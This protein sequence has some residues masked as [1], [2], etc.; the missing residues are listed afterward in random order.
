MKNVVELTKIFLKSSF[1]NFNIQIGIQT[2]SKKVFSKLLYF[3]GFLYLVGVLGFLSYSLIDGFINIGQQEVFI[4]VILF[5]IIGF[6]EFQT[7]FTSVNLL[8]F[9][10]DSE[11]ILPLPLRPY[12]IVFARSIVLVVLEYIV[13]I[14]IGLVP[15]TLYGIQTGAET[16]YYVIMILVL[17]LI[18]I[19]PIILI[20]T[21]VMIIMT[22]GRFSKN[23]NRFQFIATIFTLILVFAI[24]IASSGASGDIS[25]EEMAQKLM[26]A[27]GIVELAKQ[28]FPTLNFLVKALITTNISEAIIEIIKT[29]VVI[30]VSILVYL[31]IGNKIYLKGLVGNLFSGNS[32]KIKIKINENQYK[33]S[34]LYKTYIGKEFKILARNPIF[35]MQCL[36][37][38]LLLP[39]LIIG[40]FYV[41]INS[42][43]GE[44][45][46][47]LVSEIDMNSLPVACIILGIIS[48]F[49]MFIYISITAI[50]RDGNNAVFMKYIPISLYKQYI[51]KIIPNII[52]NLFSIII[53]LVITQI[54]LK[55]KIIVDLKRPK[56][57]W[58]SEYV[59][60]K[61]NFNLLF[62]A[63]FE[64]INI[65]ILVAT[66]IFLEGLGLYG[67][68]GIL[69]FIFLIA[70]YYT[71]KYLYNNQKQLADKII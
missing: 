67:G 44:T 36:I 46:T 33:N 13:E 60:V 8:Y 6:V 48:F 65:G 30:F 39:L 34:K 27:N 61:Q 17:L 58:D 37:P 4:G 1:S 70:T 55:L 9:T 23:K 14:F 42:Q 16:F 50:S 12:Q 15:L 18:P 24:S 47:T 69:F 59:V 41:E 49:R 5:G 3:L 64:M 10:K 19:L 11:F 21:I 2:N 26:K 68:L 22:F 25:N 45:F 63:I 20:S 53:T 28:Y 57:V 56:L 66:G 35:L 71:N 43:E 54:L 51:Y 62:Q 31:Y 32:K 7:I 29:L 38:A 40:I 52:M